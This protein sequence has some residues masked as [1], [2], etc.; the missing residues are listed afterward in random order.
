ME[1]LRQI[2]KIR[3][4]QKRKLKEFLKESIKEVPV[5]DEV[6]EKLASVGNWDEHEIM[7]CHPGHDL[8]GKIKSL[9]RALETYW[10]CHA[11]LIT[12]LDQF[13]MA[14]RDGTLFG[15]PRKAELR[16]HETGCR[17]EIFALSAAAAALVDLARH[18]TKNITIPNF[19]DELANNFNLKQQAFVKELRNQLNHVT[20]FESNWSINIAW[21]TKDTE[22]AQT[23]HFEF[24]TAELLRDGDFNDEAQAYIQG[25]KGRIDVRNLFETYS[26]SVR[27]FYAWLMP[28]IEARLSA[29]VQDYRRCVRARRANSAR[30]GYRILLGHVTPE[31]DLYGHLH[32]YLTKEELGEIDALPHR[33]KLQ[34]DRVIQMVDE[35]GACDD[36]MRGLVY[37]TFGVVE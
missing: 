21:S 3:V 7:S 23:S 9:E 4:E 11:D 33:S 34:I 26:N 35:Y 13:D 6:L 5:I 24:K 25:Q 30:S 15:R 28:E 29:E 1:S 14:S 16:E 12:R 32:K 17:K 22:P 37:K 18:V 20:F 10:R 8:D 19:Q 27:S 2:T 36:E 31:T